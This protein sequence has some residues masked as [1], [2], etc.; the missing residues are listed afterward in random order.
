MWGEKGVINRKNS[1]SSGWTILLLVLK[2]QKEIWFAVEGSYVWEM[3]SSPSFIL[4]VPAYG[5]SD[6]LP[7]HND[8]D[9][10]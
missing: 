10:L 1:L 9:L 3:L 6:Q 7:A 4:K 8:P 5:K 2:K